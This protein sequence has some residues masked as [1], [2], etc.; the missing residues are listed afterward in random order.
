VEVSTNWSRLRERA[1]RPAEGR[2]GL[3]AWLKEKLDLAQYRPRAIEDAMVS[4]LT[5]REGEYYVIKNPT[6]RT[7]HRLSDRDYFLWQR[8]DG[9]RSVKDL[10]VAYFLEYGSFAFA[11]VA[12]LV[13]GLKAGFLLSERPINVYRSAREQL[14]R[15]RPG[16]W[17]DRL[18]KAFLQKEMAINGLDRFVGHVYRWGGK[19]LFTWPAQIL[20]VVISAVGI[21]LFVRIF[22]SGTYSLV[23]TAGSYWLGVAALI[24]ANL[25]SVF[26]HEMSHALT[27]KHYGR[28]VR[29]GGFMLY[30]GTPAFFVDTTDIWMEG[31]RA[32]LAVTWAG[33]YSGLVLSGLACIAMTVWPDFLLNS[34]LFKFVFLTNISVLFNLNP[35]LELD[36]YYL[37]MDW[38][39]IP[40]L[41][42]R[43]LAFIRTGLWR[44]LKTLWTARNQ[45]R[46]GWAAF[47][48][49][50]RLFAAF[51]LLSGAWTAYALYAAANFWQQRLAEGLRSLWV[52]GGS[53]TQ[54]LLAV[55]VVLLSLPF[56]L[57]LGLSLLRQVRNLLAWVARRGLFDNQWTV[58]GLLL[59]V[60]LGLTLAPARLNYPW[61]PTVLVLLS[62]ASSCAL[63]ALS[64]R[65]YR[66]SRLAAF[67]SWLAGTALALLLMRAVLAAAGPA[68]LQPGVVRI[69]TLALGH[70]AYAS[71][72]VAGS[73]LFASTD[74]KELQRLEKGLLGGGLLVV[75]VLVLWLCAGRPLAGLPPLDAALAAAG[76]VAPVL[77]LVLLVPALV[78]FWRTGLGAAWSGLGLAWIVLAAVTILGG[79]ALPGYLLLAAALFLHVLGYLRM[80][81]PSKQPVAQADL[82][83]QNRLQRAF[84]W[85][86]A[87]A[88][89]QLRQIGGERAMQALAERF[90]N[91]ALAAGWPVSLV[92][93]EVRD[94]IPAGQSLIERG[95]TYGAALTLLLDLIAKEIGEKLTVRA[96]Q[97]GY[98]GLPWEEREIGNQYLFRDV[99][100]AESLSAEFRATRQEY[101]NLLGRMPLFATMDDQEIGLLISR[102]QVEAY[103]PGQRIIRQGQPG[104]R[105]YMVRRGHVE[106]SQRDANGVTRVVNQLD[107]GDTFGEVALLRD[108]PRNATCRATVPT[109]LLS[110]SRSDFDQLVKS[111]FV[112]RQKLDLSLA[113]AELLR[114][115]PLFDELDGSQIQAVAAQ[116]QEEAFAAGDVIIRQGEIG[117]KFYVI[118]SGRLA[119]T[120]TQ[121]GQEKAVTER[122]PGEYVGEIALLLQVPRTATVKALTAAQLLSLRRDDFERLV[123]AHLRASR[124]LERETSRRMMD[125]QRAVP[126]G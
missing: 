126:A 41:R 87:V 74:L 11:R 9:T 104:D 5:G 61:L 60:V 99:K 91:Y 79:S 121:D 123:A 73:I 23:T 90:N 27:V 20:F 49:E 63:A 29:R 125:L 119:V 34:V 120:T 62:L 22:Q 75:Y 59:I 84:G 77:V 69:V 105:F 102:L 16:H 36:G 115:V 57:T 117:E 55:G 116:L 89:A 109:E 21:Y 66:G 52:R 3:W 17:L 50:E 58:A 47:S 118:E 44:K 7:Y 103:A 33:P 78:S 72:L 70:M 53:A 110:L 37:L 76:S 26:L 86:A 18:W 12:M 95:E 98:D 94:A 100:R 8:M 25:V 51:G 112:L 97:G 68:A 35:L 80:A 19:L 1:S 106:V 67:F 101:R 83:D 32:R 111:R 31:K 45:K 15:R 28:E 46:M 113:R 71:L 14:Q 81:L 85:T 65:N 6:E 54:R 48:R 30:F 56:V 2:V 96:L 42:R 40:M 10:V 107:R 82:S 43:S 124:G 93:G 24:I 13:A 64:A 38:L 88:V 92:K 114:R 122:G 108:E 39:E 4:R